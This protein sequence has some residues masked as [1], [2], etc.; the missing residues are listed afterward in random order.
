MVDPRFASL[1]ET[2]LRA[3][4]SA[5][6]A[7]RA[8]VEIQSHFQQ[9]VDAAVARG[10]RLNE[11]RLEAHSLVGSDQ[12][13][14]QEFTNRP[15]LQS[16]ASRRAG[17]CFTMLPLLCFVAL[18]AALMALICV[19]CYELQAYLHRVLVPPD[20]G[21]L[22]SLGV[23]VTILWIV[24]ILI[25]ATFGALAYRQRVALKWPALG[26]GTLCCFV[27]LINVTM[28]IRQGVSP[29]AVGASMG[30]SVQSLPG[31]AARA[32]VMGALVLVPLYLGARR[33]RQRNMGPLTGPS[34][35]DGS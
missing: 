34:S 8:S 12:A 11:A 10:A 19:C 29:G 25:S 4:V 32:A 27:S 20:V 16:W 1:A 7:K 21:T 30:L 9:L 3:G 31:Q 35:R 6:Y 15:E 5:R 22:I 14:V 23:R 2:L 18:A 13:L 28:I 17:V 24:P 33:L 26:I